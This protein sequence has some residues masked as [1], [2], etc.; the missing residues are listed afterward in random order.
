MNIAVNKGFTVSFF[1]L[2]ARVGFD[3][4]VELD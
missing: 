3:G 2:E 1:D 4:P